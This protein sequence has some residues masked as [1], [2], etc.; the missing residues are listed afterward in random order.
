MSES[1]II[2]EAIKIQRMRVRQSQPTSITRARHQ[3]KLAQLLEL[4]QEFDEIYDKLNGGFYDRE[5]PDTTMAREALDE[6]E[7]EASNI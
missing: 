7:R 3:H 1:T 5:E 6:I 2:N 4:E